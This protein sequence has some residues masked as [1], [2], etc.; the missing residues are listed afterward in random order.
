[1]HHFPTQESVSRLQ[2]ITRALCKH[3]CL[4]PGSRR[5]LR[6]QQSK[7]TRCFLILLP[8]QL[9]LPEG[10]SWQRHFP[11]S[12]QIQS[13]KTSSSWE[14]RSDM[15]PQTQSA[16]RAFW[17]QTVT[18]IRGMQFIH[19]DFQSHTCLWDYSV[20]NHIKTPKIWPSELFL[21]ITPCTLGASSHPDKP[22]NWTRCPSGQD[23]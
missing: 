14:D 11:T 22:V 16:P 17:P 18:K 4:C 13:G 19:E 20:Q 6:G 2:I 12:T 7:G 3:L 21:F 8:H 9:W 1:M 5:L 15:L 23:F 10:H